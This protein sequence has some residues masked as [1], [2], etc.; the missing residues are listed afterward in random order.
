MKEVKLN[1]T[2]IDYVVDSYDQMC[3]IAHELA[4]E[5]VKSGKVSNKEWIKR[6]DYHL[7][8]LMEVWKYQL[9]SGQIDVGMRE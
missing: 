4:D 1:A 8:R 3:K 9:S 7:A 2:D 6:V 5:E